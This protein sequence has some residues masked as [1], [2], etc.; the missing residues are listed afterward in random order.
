VT[1]PG[2]LAARAAPKIAINKLFTT[3]ANMWQTEGQ[4]RSQEPE[5]R[6]AGFQFDFYSFCGWLGRQFSKKSDLLISTHH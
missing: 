1:V 5:C 3:E 2:G 6:S 4:V